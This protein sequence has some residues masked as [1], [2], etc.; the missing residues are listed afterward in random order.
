MSLWRFR[1]GGRTA[2]AAGEISAQRAQQVG[3][4]QHVRPAQPQRLPPAAARPV[5]RP[6]LARQR[7]R[8][9]H[10]QLLVLLQRPGESRG[11]NSE[12]GMTASV[13]NWHV[14]FC[15]IK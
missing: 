3:G 2:G 10:P 1:E 11:E 7:L 14:G 6:A 4:Q 8:H 9:H 12:T 15:P 13:L 5:E